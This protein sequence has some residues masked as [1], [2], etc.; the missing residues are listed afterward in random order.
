MCYVF[1]LKCMNMQKLLKRNNEYSTILE[2]NK[3]EVENLKYSPT[4]S[5]ESFKSENE[6]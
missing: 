6:N 3:R 4:I 1:L 5:S 2:R